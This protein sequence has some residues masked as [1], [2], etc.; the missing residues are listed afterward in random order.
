MKRK[1]N[2]GGPEGFLVV[3]KPAGQT[4]HDVVG[5]V[6][7]AL[8]ERRVGHGGTLDPDATAQR[9]VTR[10]A[11]AVPPDALAETAPAFL[12]WSGGEALAV[13]WN[14]G[15]AAAEW[16]RYGSNGT[17]TLVAAGGRLRTTYALDVAA[18]RSEA[19]AFA[20]KER[21]W[22]AANPNPP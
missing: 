19:E 22:L 9:A 11:L 1:H 21:D 6:R 2:P 16:K 5:A 10:S 14:P 17:L 7:R 12:G 20:Q 8:G 18:S 4:S 15:E 13:T 3:D